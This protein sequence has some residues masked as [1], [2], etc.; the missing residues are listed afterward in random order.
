APFL[1]L[2]ATGACGSMIE[3]LERLSPQSFADANVL[4]TFHFYEPY[5]FSHQGAPWMTG[6]PMYRYLNDVPWPSAA[7]SREATR[8]A[9]EARL[10]ADRSTPDSEKRAIRV[11]IDRVLNEYFDARPDR[12]FIERHF[13]RVTVWADRYDIERSRILLG[14][15]GA[16]R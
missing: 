2:V 5:V 9:V 13:A 3:G 15:F 11:T 16:M 7:G 6:E 10:A 12:R 8:I 1:T 4:Y 14:E